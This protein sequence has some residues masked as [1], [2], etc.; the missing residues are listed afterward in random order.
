MVGSLELSWDTGIYW[1]VWRFI[2]SECACQRADIKFCLVIHITSFPV[3][4]HEISLEVLS[5]TG[6]YPASKV[7]YS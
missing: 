2:Q 1:P 3:A 6:T 5:C 7:Y 4:I